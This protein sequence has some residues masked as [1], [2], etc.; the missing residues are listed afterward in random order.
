M[1]RH[2]MREGDGTHMRVAGSAVRQGLLP[3]WQ[4]SYRQDKHK[5]GAFEATTIGRLRAPDCCC[6]SPA[7]CPEGRLHCKPGKKCMIQLTTGHTRPQHKTQ[8]MQAAWLTGTNS[9]VLGDLK[10][11][12]QRAQGPRTSHARRVQRRACSAAHVVHPQ[13]HS[14]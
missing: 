6:L 10:T 5:L 14:A 12:K 1:R 3:T 9:T 13:C 8:V 11:D 2:A 7:A 4:K